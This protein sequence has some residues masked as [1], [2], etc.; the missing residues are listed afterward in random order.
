MRSIRILSIGN[1]FSR[2]SFYYLPGLLREAGYDDVKAAYLAVGGCSIEKHLQMALSGENY[3]YMKNTDGTWVS[4]ESDMNAGLAD[5]DWD[6][7]V[8]HQQTGASGKPE[9]LSCLDDLTGFVQERCTNPGVMFLWNMTWTFAK[10]YSRE[11]FDYYGRDQMKMYEAIA[12]TVRSCIMT[13]KAFSG[14]V[15]TGTAFMNFRTSYFGDNANE[16]GLHA[17]L[18]VGRFLAAMTFAAYLSG[19]DANL[20]GKKYCPEFCHFYNMKAMREAVNNAVE[21]PFDITPS[22]VISKRRLRV[23][24]AGDGRAMDSARYLWDFLNEKNIAATVGILVCGSDF[25]YSDSSYRKKSGPSGW[26]EKAASLEEA[27]N[28]ERW[29]AVILSGT[30]DDLVENELSP[31]AELLKKIRSDRRPKLLWNMTWAYKDG[32]D[33]PGFEKYGNSRQLMYEA[34]LS[35]AKDRIDPD[36]RVFSIIPS[37]VTVEIMRSSYLGDTITVNGVDLTEDIGSYAVSVT[38]AAYL[39]GI[40]AKK[41]HYLPE[42]GKDEIEPVRMIINDAIYYAFRQP[43]KFRASKYIE[44][45]ESGLDAGFGDR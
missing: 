20:L 10:D 45:A 28:D 11:A 38:A 17:G 2:D 4:T 42:N 3:S 18:Y 35:N 12:G 44:K 37:A 34:I 24:S 6:Y 7:I 41:F 22:S 5:E 23:L 43:Y 31:I 40:P 27:L 15:P 29:D 33:V 32:A 21:H 19:T 9:S 39:T 8:F 16:D 25:S 13:R 30:P 14:V 36:R 26:T 1:S